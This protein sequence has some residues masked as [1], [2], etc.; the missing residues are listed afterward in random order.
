[1]YYCASWDDSLTGPV[2]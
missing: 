1:D 2:F